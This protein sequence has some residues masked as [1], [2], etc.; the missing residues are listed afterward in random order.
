MAK[1][2]QFNYITYGAKVNAEDVTKLLAHFTA[3]F[4]TSETPE[5]PTPFCIWGTHGIGK[6]ELV[7]SF[8]EEAGYPF[9][10]IAPAQFE[11]MGDLIGMPKIE[12]ADGHATTRFV[13]PEWVPKHDGPG[14]FLID[15]V[16]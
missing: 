13:P 9:I 8:A 5:R 6:T 16:N 10:Y 14:I 7:R 12:S 11:E 2:Q 4:L 1:T 3:R 15:D